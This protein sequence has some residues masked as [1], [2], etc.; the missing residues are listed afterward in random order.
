MQPR[1]ELLPTQDWGGQV[2]AGAGPCSL[3]GQTGAHLFGV[4]VL[5]RLWVRYDY[6][7]VVIV[8]IFLVCEQLKEAEENGLS[9]GKWRE[10]RDS[11][12]L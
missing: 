5:F 1:G 3:P 4:T 11:L 12:P 2:N 8:F 9:S 6:G 7:C 10:D